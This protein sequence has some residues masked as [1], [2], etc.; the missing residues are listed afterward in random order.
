MSVPK[1][2]RGHYPELNPELVPKP[3][4][5]GSTRLGQMV[6]IMSNSTDQWWAESGLMLRVTV[7]SGVHGM[8]IEGTD[9]IDE[10]GVFVEDP[11]T[12]FGHKKIEHYTYRTQPEGVCSGPGDLDLVAYSLRKYVGLAT[13]GNPTVLVPLFVKDP[14]IQYINEFG[15]ELREN[16]AWFASK[17]AGERFRGY[18]YSQRQGLLGKRSGGTRNKGRADLRARLGFD[19]KF[20]AH[21]IRLGMQGVEYLSTGEIT[22]PVP[23]ANLQYLRDLKSGVYL[24]GHS[25]DTPK[26]AELAAAKL[27]ETLRRAERLEAQLDGLIKTT[28]LPDEPDHQAIDRWV[29]DVHFRHW[30][31]KQ[32]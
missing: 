25:P 27:A 14:D 24:E 19:A 18:M 6:P 2:L 32:A 10:M 1:G 17:R 3:T 5:V 30:G 28:R 15:R 23:G 22:L 16:R 31:L 11:T 13:Q 26:G 7:G 20:A 8:A 29:A 12:V 21:M 9:D 4:H